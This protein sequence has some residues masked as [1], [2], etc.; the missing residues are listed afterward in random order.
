MVQLLSP[1]VLTILLCISSQ[2]LAAPGTTSCTVNSGQNG[3]CIST[4]SCSSGGGHS[5]AGH[6]PGA[7]DI[8]VSHLL[9]HQF[10]KILTI[11]VVLHIRLLLCRQ[12]PWSLPAH[13]LLLWRYQHS[14]PLSWPSRY[15]MLHLWQLQRFWS[16]WYLPVYKHVLRHENSRPLPWPRRRSMLHQGQR[17]WRRWQLWCARC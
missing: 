16:I 3:V 5:E 14:R 7:A 4:G 2:S 8:Q 10:P 12:C 13:R 9:S 15:S 6:C 1:S 11:Y 17:R